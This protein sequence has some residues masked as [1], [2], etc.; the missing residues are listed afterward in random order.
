MKKIVKILT[1][2]AH[3]I[4]YTVLSII[5]LP[6]RNKESQVWLLSERGNDARDNSYWMYKYIKNKYPNIHVK[7]VITLSSKDSPKIEQCDRIKY[8]SLRHYYYASYAAVLMSTHVCGYTPDM[9]LFT[10]LQKMGLYK[11]KGT[12]IYLQHGI[13]ISDIKNV[14]YVDLIISGA[15]TEYEQI[16]KQN[17]A[18][19]EKTVLTGFARFDNLPKKHKNM[20]SIVFMPTFRRW[21]NYLSEKE[22]KSGNYYKAIQSLLNNTKLNAFLVENN[23]TLYFYPHYETQKRINTFTT[24]CKNII[25]ADFNNY[26]VQELL[27]K[28][29]LLITD[30]S[31]VFFDFGYMGKPTIY[32]Q[33]DEK[34]FFEKHYKRGPF[35][36]KNDGFGEIVNKESDLIE[37]IINYHLHGYSVK[38]KYRRR[39]L[40]FFGKIDDKNRERIMKATLKMVNKK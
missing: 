14:D 33:F 13:T 10:R 22:F 35:N 23:L 32:Y 12:Q 24:S 37:S 19:R 8:G 3:L 31:S 20:K 21:N 15:K 5:F 34:D 36:Y 27:I 11:P 1:M 17:K 25:I 4:K 18:Y 9:S 30:Y 38:D 29:D 40:S 39:I 2:L 6:V 26:D 16:I 28:G 7:Y